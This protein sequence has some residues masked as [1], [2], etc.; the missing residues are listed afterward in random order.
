MPYPLAMKVKDALQEG[1]EWIGWAS[2]PLKKYFDLGK[3]G[4]LSGTS[5]KQVTP[6]DQLGECPIS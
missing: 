6:S 2:A 1:W 5:Q 3:G 4:A